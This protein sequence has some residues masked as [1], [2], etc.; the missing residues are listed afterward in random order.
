VSPKRFDKDLIPALRGLGEAAGWDCRAVDG[1][2]L[3]DLFA[4][5]IAVRFVAPAWTDLPEAVR[6]DIKA[7]VKAVQQ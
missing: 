3:P 6:T 5:R 1:A 7:I 2:K 4:A